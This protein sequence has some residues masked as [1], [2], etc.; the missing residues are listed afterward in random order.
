MDSDI[1]FLE[2]E[3]GVHVCNV[4]DEGTLCGTFCGGSDLQ[5]TKKRTVTCKQCIN[6]L[7]LY[8]KVRFKEDE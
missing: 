1:C 5:E 8:R 6:A 2:D 4:V 7:K 3:D